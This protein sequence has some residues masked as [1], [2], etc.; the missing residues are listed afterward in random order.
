MKIVAIISIALLLFVSTTNGQMFVDTLD[1]ADDGEDPDCCMGACCVLN[2]QYECSRTSNACFRGQIYASGPKCGAGNNGMICKKPTNDATLIRTKKDSEGN[3]WTVEGDTLTKYVNGRQVFQ[4]ID[5]KGA[6][7]TLPGFNRFRSSQTVK[8]IHV[9]TDDGRI[10]QF[11]GKKRVFDSRT[12]VS[13]TGVSQTRT[14]GP[15]KWKKFGGGVYQFG[16]FVKEPVSGGLKFE[17]TFG[18]LVSLSPDRR[19]RGEKNMNLCKLNWHPEDPFNKRPFVNTPY[20]YCLKY[21]KGGRNYPGY[22]PRYNRRLRSPHIN[23]NDKYKRSSKP[24]KKMSPDYFN[25]DYFDVFDN[26]FNT[27]D[28][29]DDGWKCDTPLPTSLTRKVFA[30]ESILAKPFCGRPVYMDKNDN[31]LKEGP[32]TCPY[33]ASSCKGN[34]VL[35]RF[36]ILRQNVKGS[37]Y[38]NC[39]A[40]VCLRFPNGRRLRRIIRRRLTKQTPAVRYMA[41]FCKCGCAVSQLSK[42]MFFQKFGEKDARYAIKQRAYGRIKYND[43]CS[44]RYNQVW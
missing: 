1:T 38:Y 5:P 26:S 4:Y 39:Y 12:G 24:K 42:K 16:G 37:I 14:W 35:K 19:P 36:K 33:S 44:Y 34:E 23:F 32:K 43:Y 8:Y 27:F 15:F 31:L 9:G 6:T 13:K 17:S 40:N 7:L 41:N 2:G 11:D 29:E 21:S 20:D 22:N 25:D 28:E 30:H 10:V 18:K 3:T